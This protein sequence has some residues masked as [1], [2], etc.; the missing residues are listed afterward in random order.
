MK[1]PKHPKYKGTRLSKNQCPT[2][3]SLYMK[4]HQQ[5]RSLP[6][7]TKVERDKSKYTRKQ[8]HKEIE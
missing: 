1:C 4:L 6:K 8:K 5:P 2:C 7:P 3:F